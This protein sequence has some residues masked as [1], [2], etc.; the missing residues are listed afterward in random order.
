MSCEEVEGVDRRVEGSLSRLRRVD[1]LD[2]SGEEVIDSR[3]GLDDS[4]VDCEGIGI[5]GGSTEGGGLMMNE[6][7]EGRIK[8]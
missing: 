6:L 4:E 8:C 3:N 2:S 7:P 5:V 1:E